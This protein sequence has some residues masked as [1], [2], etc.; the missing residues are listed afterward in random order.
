MVSCASRLAVAPERNIVFH[1]AVMSTQS[2][3]RT[4]AE[5]EAFVGRGERTH[6]AGE[7]EASMVSIVTPP[8]EI[9]IATSPG[10]NSAAR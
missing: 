3:T 2:A 10:P 8:W 7:S 6:L 1:A 9:P 5:F 4:I